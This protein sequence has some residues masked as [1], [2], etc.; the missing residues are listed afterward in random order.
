M[1]YKD[2]LKAKAA[3]RNREHAERATASDIT[4]E[5]ELAMRQRAR[6]CPLCGV[7]MTGKP[8]LPNSKELDH[9][10]PICQGGTHTHGN[11]RIICRRCNQSRP[12]DGS[13]YSGTLT[14]W[15]EDPVAVARLRRETCRKGLHPWMPANI[16]INPSNGYKFCGPCREAWEQKERGKRYQQ[17]K[18]GA[19]FAASGRTF[20]CPA[21][22]DTAARQAADLH[23][24]GYLTW[25]Q[26]AD[27]VGYS[28]AEGAR[29]AA[30][31]IGYV[32]AARPPKAEPERPCPDCGAPKRKHA[33][34][35]GPCSAAKAQ[36]VAELY[37]DGATL[38]TLADQLGHSSI[39]TVSNLIK[40]AGVVD[41]RCG[42]P[43]AN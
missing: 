37:E 30:K 4:H 7:Y 42:R 3:R 14:L 10:L 28:T 33:R 39:T 19:L 15:A 23:A 40:S 41:L 29:F 5:Q 21:C 31:R 1:P 38:R 22:V 36:R 2:P 25:Q 13:D 6:K 18:C 43:R 17:C 26:V 12:K 34:Q 16:K 11:V 35:C 27:R 8:S 24:L 9:I 32:P 20:M